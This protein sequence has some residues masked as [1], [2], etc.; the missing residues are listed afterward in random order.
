MT[1]QVL[2]V[3]IINTVGQLASE[4]VPGFEK[5]LG[6]VEKTKQQPGNINYGTFSDALKQGASKRAGQI[7]AMPDVRTVGLP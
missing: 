1:A 4:A 7:K 5:A 3:L 6:I 2:M